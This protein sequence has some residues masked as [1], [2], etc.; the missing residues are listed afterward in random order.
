MASCMLEKY[1]RCRT[2]KPRAAAF[3]EAAALGVV[4]IARCPPHG[5]GGHSACIC[6]AGGP[7]HH[8]ETS[9]SRAITAKPKKTSPDDGG[10][11]AG[12]RGGGSIAGR[13]GTA[14]RRQI[15]FVPECPCS[16]SEPEERTHGPKN[17]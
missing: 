1:V 7:G 11:A 8:F 4:N 6:G 3:R 16:Q 9:H 2:R 15:L 12:V 14:E 17:D 13:Q 10:I 5:V